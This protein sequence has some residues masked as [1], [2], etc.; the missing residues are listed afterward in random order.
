MKKLFRLSVGLFLLT[1]LA[2]P[3]FA[4]GIKFFKGNLEEAIAKAKEENKLVFIDAYAAW[5]GPC[6]MM[7]RSTFK[8]DAVGEYYNEKFINVKLNVDD[9]SNEQFV[10][11]QAIRSI[12]YYAFLNGEGTVVHSGMGF[13][14]ESEFIQLGQT[15]M[16]YWQDSQMSDADIAEQAPGA[17]KR[18]CAI[19]SP[20]LKIAQQIEAEGEAAKMED[21][22]DDIAKYS[23]QLQAFEQEFGGKMNNPAFMEA[24]MTALK[25][26]CSEVYD[27]MQEEEG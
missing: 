3:S 5:C 11:A 17:A 1:A 9:K 25:G 20:M 26:E 23:E 10:S 4:A 6:K 15:A 14:E 8:E 19:L 22:Q 21:Y 2:T 16:G 7:D 24:F 27:M 12:P 18:A 13:L